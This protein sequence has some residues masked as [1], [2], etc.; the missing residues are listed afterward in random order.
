[1]GLVE[2]NVLEK[3]ALA[4]AGQLSGTMYTFNVQTSRRKVD[5]NSG[6]STYQQAY[7]INGCS[8]FKKYSMIDTIKYRIVHLLLG[9]K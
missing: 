1:M 4:E 8:R 7:V 5:A 6:T 3:I 9:T 2:A